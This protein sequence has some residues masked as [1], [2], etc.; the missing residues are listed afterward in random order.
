MTM[1]MLS[2]RGAAAESSATPAA[3]ATTT[4]TPLAP[5]TLASASAAPASASASSGPTSTL[6]VAQLVAF[7]RFESKDPF[8]QQVDVNSGFAPGEGTAPSAGSSGSAPIT[9]PAAPPPPSPQPPAPAATATAAV[10]S[11]NGGPNELLVP[12]ADF[13]AAPA[14]PVFHL[15]SLG[16]DSVRISIAGGSLA[17]GAPTVTLKRGKPLTLV[18]TADGTEYELRLLWVGAGTP[19]PGLVTSATSVP[20][21]PPP[22]APSGQ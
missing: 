21:S 4:T 13:P 12:G 14:D 7:D 15:V 10:I 22:A 8:E 9:P 2:K 17:S 16:R 11:V 3:A 1:K 19:P 18:N 5:P 20:T 6:S